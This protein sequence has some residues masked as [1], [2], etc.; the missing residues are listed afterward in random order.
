MIAETIGGVCRLM[1]GAA[2]GGPRARGTLVML[3]GCDASRH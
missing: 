2:A 3:G 1:T